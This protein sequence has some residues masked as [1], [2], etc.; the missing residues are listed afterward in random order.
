M[1]SQKL[2]VLVVGDRLKSFSSQKTV[3]AISELENLIEAQASGHGEEKY[4]VT[5]GQGVH[6]RHL[7][8]INEKLLSLNLSERFA[9]KLPSTFKRSNRALTHKHKSKNITISEPVRIDA[10]NYE[11]ALMLDE[12][13]AEMSDHLTG[14][15]IQGMVLIE[16]AR[17]T[18]IAV[19]KKYFISENHQS[20]ISFVTNN[21]NAVFHAFV[22]PLPVLI[23]YEIIKIKQLLNSNFN[24][25]SRILFIQNEKIC[26][27]II[28]DF[29]A[30]CENFLK[31]R[32]DSLAQESILNYFNSSN[33]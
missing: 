22:F 27:E 17:Q 1:A 15:H 10:S 20:K 5:I 26:V 6:E 11:C 3:M 16:A 14:K 25:K 21:T 7:Q 13:L 30:L 23:R 24:C 31:A 18:V 33:Q 32:E 19:S 2:K 12:R 28:F 4:V 29:S 9:I 8:R